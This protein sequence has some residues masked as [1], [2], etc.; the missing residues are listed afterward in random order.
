MPELS[1]KQLAIW[2]LIVAVVLFIGARALRGSERAT[3]VAFD[4]VALD[5][6]SDPATAFASG[7]SDGLE[8]EQTRGD[9]AAEG[10][11]EWVHVHVAGAVRRP[12][13]YR[14]PSS[15]RVAAALQRAGGP[16]RGA[17][18]DRINLAANLVDG[19]QILVPRKGDAATA[20]AAQPGGP[21]GA[22]SGQP[23]GGQ[24][25]SLSRATAAELETLE[26]IGPVTA[27]KILAFRD[28]EGPIKSIEQLDAIPGIGPAT[29]QTLRQALV[30]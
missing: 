17:D 14:L 19:E 9:G 21:N 24:S 28:S 26:G 22:G 11:K 8:I 10:A 30:P 4:P 15:G 18:L 20:V 13:L 3:S 12:G 5:N 23:N 25:I 27:G 1:P 7:D 6:A 2:I 16:T 29:M